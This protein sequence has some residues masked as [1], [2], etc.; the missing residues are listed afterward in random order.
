MGD[1]SPASRP[2][3]TLVWPAPHSAFVYWVM[4]HWG[5]PL[6][7]KEGRSVNQSHDRASLGVTNSLA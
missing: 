6:L 1:R 7:R 2:G 5:V 3:G 4:A